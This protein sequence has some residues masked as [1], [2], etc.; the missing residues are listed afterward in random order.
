VALTADHIRAKLS[1]VAARW[2]IGDVGIE[3]GS[4][5]LSVAVEDVQR[6]LVHAE[7][8]EPE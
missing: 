6:V 2:G 8:P 5:P 3:T 1:A 7:T 4:G